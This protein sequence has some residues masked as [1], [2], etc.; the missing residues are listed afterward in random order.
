MEEAKV[1]GARPFVARMPASFLFKRSQCVQL[2]YHEP[3][4][5]LDICCGLRQGTK[6]GP[7]SFLIV[8]N[9]ILAT[10]PELFKFADDLTVLS[11][12]L[13]PP[14]TEQSDVT[15]IFNDLKAELGKVKLTVSETKTSYMTFSFLKDDS[16]SSIAD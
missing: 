16:H 9:R 4:G 15:R 14:T 11:L 1:M 7:L 2:P 5:F 6:L 12:Q 10:V 3:S 13:I 8:F